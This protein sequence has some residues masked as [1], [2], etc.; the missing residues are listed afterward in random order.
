[1]HEMSPDQRKHHLRKVMNAEVGQCSPEQQG[2][3]KATSTSITAILPI[4]YN[5]MVT[6]GVDVAILSSIWTKAEKYL[7]L[8]N[9]IIEEPTDDLT[10]KC[11][12]F[13]K[14]HA[15]QPNVVIARQDGM[16]HCPC[17]MFTTT[18]NLWSHAVAVAHRKGILEGFLDKVREKATGEP[19][20]YAASTVNVN[21]RYAGQKGGRKGGGLTPL[22]PGPQ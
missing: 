9:A 1:M 2:R 11:K 15:D 13:S 21:I 7:G 6:S 14:S 16:I 3:S 19:N 17:L 10:K 5:A 22:S 12:V 8:P 20:L 4:S 18:P